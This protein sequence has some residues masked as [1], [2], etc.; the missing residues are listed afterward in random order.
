MRILKRLIVLAAIF[1]VL[2]HVPYSCAQRGTPTGGPKD[3]IP[4]AFVKSNPPNYSINFD[5]EI[6][7]IDFDEYILLNEPD[8][9]ILV[10]PPLEN[11]PI[12]TPQGQALRYLELEFSDTLEE[13]KTYTINF[14]HS[15]EDNNEGN[16]LSY[17]K[18]VF[19]T[20]DYLDSLYVSGSV[21]DAYNRE[22]SE[23]VSVMLYKLDSTYSDS[24]VFKEPP[25]Y[26]AYTRDTTHAFSIEN[27][28]EGAYKMIALK[29]ENQNYTYEK[30]KEKMGFLEDTINLPTDEVYNLKIFKEDLDYK[31]V[32]VEQVAQRHFLFSFDGKQSDSVS[33]EL[34]SSKP[35]D[36]R[37][38]YYKQVDHDSIDYWFEPAFD[39][40]EVDSLVFEVVKGQQRDT[41]M[42]KL[43]EDIEAD[44]LD[45]S[46]EPSSGIEMTEQFELSANTPLVEID[47]SLIN[48]V[49]KD[50]VAVPFDQTYKSEGNKYVFDFKL[51]EKE[52]YN[53]QAL[54]G[55]LTDF[56]GT[57][58]DTLNYE[59]ST[60]SASEYAD[61]ALTL[62]N[63]AEFPIIVQLVN[64]QGETKRELI[65][66]EEDGNVFDFRYVEPGEYYVRVI[67][68]SND[69]GVWDTGNYLKHKQ[70]E[71][72]IY[73]KEPLDVRKNWEITQTFTLEN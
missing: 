52:N 50:S 69:N 43:G 27:I 39:E 70:P 46:S 56:Y 58:N 37:D 1:A 33:I 22:T 36:F 26:I 15:I 28:E 14:G 3:T 10:S 72:V 62:Q 12:I 49:N 4:P 60:K 47:T 38:T 59:L 5:K 7:R 48:I 51:K 11:R 16:A 73:M 57:E 53:I 9:Q 42:T 41:L 32:S 21:T 63:I 64:E 18:Y 68:D 61:V 67:Y 44:S 34:L 55:A 65:H 20:G 8:E 6:I 17:F 30:G 31:A 29:D 35:D 54:P 23:G 45:I 25:T 19:S 71:E 2:F 40:E 66:Q 24:I 13:D